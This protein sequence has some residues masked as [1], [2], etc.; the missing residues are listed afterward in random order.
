ML[1]FEFAL[2]LFRLHLQWQ[3]L[4]SSYSIPKIGSGLEERDGTR[5]M[6]HSGQWGSTI[7]RRLLLLVLVSHRN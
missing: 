6:Q 1:L 3:V 7:P 5:L 4:T 2:P